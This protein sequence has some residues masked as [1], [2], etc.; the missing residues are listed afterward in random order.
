MPSTTVLVVDDARA[1]RLLCRVNL[2]LDGHTV[3]EAATLEEARLVLGA[4]PVEIVLLDVH[5]GGGDGLELLRELQA[6][7]PGI[8]VVMLTGTAVL[9][10]AV[11]DSVDAVLGKPFKI[12]ELREVVGRLG[13]RSHGR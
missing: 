8:G 6:A 3:H 5:V 2:D 9:D 11:R 7:H 4:E 13:A 1:I 12:E 10:P